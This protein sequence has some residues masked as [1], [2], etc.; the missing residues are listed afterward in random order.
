[1][2]T[3]A[4]PQPPAS[5]EAWHEMFRTTVMQRF[6]A[7][8]QVTM[9]NLQYDRKFRGEKLASGSTFG[10]WEFLFLRAFFPHNSPYKK[11]AEA[12]LQADII[13]RK[14][15]EYV[16][17]SLFAKTAQHKARKPLVAELDLVTS[18]PLV[19]AGASALPQTPRK[20]AGGSSPLLLPADAPRGKKVAEQWHPRD[21]PMGPFF[22]F[23]IVLEYFHQK[24]RWT[25]P[26]WSRQQLRD[27]L[28][29]FRTVLSYISNV[30]PI[31]STNSGNQVQSDAVTPDSSLSDDD[32]ETSSMDELLGSLELSPLAHKTG[33]VLP[34][35]KSTKPAPKLLSEDSGGNLDE[36][37]RRYAAIDESIN[38]GFFCLL[39]NTAITRSYDC[40]ENLKKNDLFDASSPS[41]LHETDSVCVGHRKAFVVGK[42]PP[43]FTA[44]VD[45]YTRIPI[46][47][48][49][50]P[51]PEPSKTTASEDKTNPA[52]IGFIVE[53]KRSANQ[54]PRLKYQITAELVGWIYSRRAEFAVVFA[55]R[56]NQKQQHVLLAQFGGQYVFFYI[57]SFGRSYLEYLASVDGSTKPVPVDPK[58][59]GL[60]DGLLSVRGYG[61]FNIVT[62]PDE[63][64][65]FLQVCIALD[66][67]ARSRAVGEKI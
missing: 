53:V 9:R 1:M 54:D 25:H 8:A 29:T 58:N 3:M 65:E 41:L 51:E 67:T 16:Q 22:N 5:E 35:V 47:M 48:K 38:V 13:D 52:N 45:A 56:V 42:D 28:D 26:P 60:A 10:F 2:P 37:L 49:D 55:Q 64:E 21:L 36:D 62:N 23:C 44:C 7:Q 19:E 20:H 61:P 27:I 31:L 43:V 24:K 39:V 63:I 40:D 34:H 6:D 33:S 57:A 50:E 11:L 59:E 14:D 17:S 18:Q 46:D 30:F 66:R 12:L 32:D 15:W 4:A